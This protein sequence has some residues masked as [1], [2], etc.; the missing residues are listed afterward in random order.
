MLNI[1]QRDGAISFDNSFNM[2]GDI[3]SFPDAF[4]GFNSFSTFCTSAGCNVL[5]R[6]GL[7]PV[8]VDTADI[9]A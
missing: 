3:M 7:I 9:I 5:K 6:N 8:I 1:L 2:R 4:H